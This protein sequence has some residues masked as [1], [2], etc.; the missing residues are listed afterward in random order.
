MKII[1]KNN[2]WS[3]IFLKWRIL[4]IKRLKKDKKFSSKSK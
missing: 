2:M 3:T 1:Y 4:Y